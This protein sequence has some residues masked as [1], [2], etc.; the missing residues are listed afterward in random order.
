MPMGLL[1]D[2]TAPRALMTGGAF[3]GA[4]A[5]QLFGMSGWVESFF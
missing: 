2:A 5:T 1:S 4:A 3:L